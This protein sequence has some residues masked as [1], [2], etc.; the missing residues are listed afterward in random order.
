MPSPLAYARVAAAL[1]LPVALAL[2]SSSGHAAADPFAALRSTARKEMSAT[3]TPGVAIGVVKG[4]RLV[5]AE[6]LGVASLE[7][8]TPV[9]ENTLFQ[10]GSLTRPFTAAAALTLAAQRKVGLDQPI[11]TY[12]PGL[13]AAIG[14]LTLAQLLAESSGLKDQVG[15]Q[16]PTDQAA[17]AAYVRSLTAADLLF[18]TGLVFSSSNPGYA[19]AGHVVA[20]VAGAPFADAMR[21]LLFAPAGMSATTFEAAPAGKTPAATG[22]G[23]GR[24]KAEPVAVSDD[25]RF[26]PATG[27][28]SSLHD[29]SRFAAAMMNNGV[30]DGRQVLPKEV[31]DAM[32]VP[33]ADARTFASE[34]TYGYGLFLRSFGMFRVAER[35][36]M[37]PSY[38]GENV[39]MPGFTADI[40]MIP[41]EGVA[42][43]VLGNR[44]GA[45]FPKTFEKA[46]ETL[47]SVPP[48][49]PV[50]G[51]YPAAPV[52]EQE[53]ASLAGRYANPWAI[54]LFVRSGQLFLRQPGVQAAA[55]TRIEGDHF[56]VT[57]PDSS[58][59]NDLLVVREPGGPP[60][61]IR[62]FEWAFKKTQEGASAA[63]RSRTASVSSAA[64]GSA[65]PSRSATMASAVR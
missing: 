21:T 36:G 13:D 3:G 32:L 11:G 42:V 29:L 61:G 6:G 44:E 1:L 53:L 64:S 12:D 10:V 65:A 33:H 50:T 35:A 8:K 23:A 47:V 43:I 63:S 34:A 20:S 51:E 2:I 41:A 52:T 5:F 31:P 14:R 54:E 39:A 48:P 26:W 16:G 60:L 18:P 58:Q 59:P 40:R 55:V 49:P 45:A 62:L 19:L 38:R 57:L 15:G 24:F 46:F 22:Y 4:G 27:A 17:L 7:T 56:L 25:L 28:W 37:A 9:T 30:V